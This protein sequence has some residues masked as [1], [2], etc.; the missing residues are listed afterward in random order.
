MIEQNTKFVATKK[1]AKVVICLT[2]AENQRSILYLKVIMYN[3]DYQSV[4]TSL[5][6]KQHC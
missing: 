1:I 4:S 3:S 6:C 5:K 2:E